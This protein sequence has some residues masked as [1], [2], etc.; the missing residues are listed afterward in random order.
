MN[1]RELI[2]VLAHEMRTPL[3]AVLGYQ[4]LLSEGIYGELDA[5]Q[6]EPV[7][8]TQRAAE[9]I[10]SL[11][12]G[13]QALT[14]TESAGSD[15]F[16]DTNTHWLTSTLGDRLMPIARGYDVKLEVESSPPQPLL[17]FPAPRFLRAAEIATVAAI[18]SS[19][20]R[21]LRLTCQY[22]DGQ[23]LCT[24]RGSGLDA[25]HDQPL[26]FTLDEHSSLRFS[27]AQLRLAMARATLTPAGGSVRL[28]AHP[29]GTVLDLLLPARQAAIDVPEGPG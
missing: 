10:L 12:D 19:Q 13:L 8:R 3:A 26:G 23:V 5:R 9:Q 28:A 11:L 29:D 25:V 6:R 21:A 24:V 14:A 20:G 4:E 22:L 27:A 18:K 16:A 7:E 2:A 15:E 17:Q 1:L